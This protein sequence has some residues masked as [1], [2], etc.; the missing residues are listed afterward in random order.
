MSHLCRKPQ[1]LWADLL[2]YLLWSLLGRRHSTSPLNHKRSNN[3]HHR[4]IL[5]SK[6][7]SS[8]DRG[9]PGWWCAHCWVVPGERGLVTSWFFSSECNVLVYCLLLWGFSSNFKNQKV[10]LCSLLCWY[11]LSFL[12][13]M[14]GSTFTPF[15][16]WSVLC[17]NNGHNLRQQPHDF[18]CQL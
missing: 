2:E 11:V 5:L 3:C 7:W 13:F 14:I 10:S 15:Q 9:W 8:A 17:S 12:E 16:C 18:S 6:A 1:P 4:F